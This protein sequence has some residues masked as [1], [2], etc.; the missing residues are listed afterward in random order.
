MCAIRQN[1]RIV[2]LANLETLHFYGFRKLRR[3]QSK[4]HSGS[5]SILR[6]ESVPARSCSAWT[7]PCQCIAVPH[8]LALRHPGGAPMEAHHI[9]L[10]MIMACDSEFKETTI[11]GKGNGKLL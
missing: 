3:C 9:M 7:P 4:L 2:R 1:A 5:G 11:K 6:P 10:H 8:P